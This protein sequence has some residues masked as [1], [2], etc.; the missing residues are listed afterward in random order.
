MTK[1]Y[2]IKM[3]PRSAPQKPASITLTSKEG[4]RVVRSAAKRVIKTH[5]AVIKALANR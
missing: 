3:K 5:A 4:S 1:N 2:G